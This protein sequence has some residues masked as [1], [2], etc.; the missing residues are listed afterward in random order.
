MK[1]VLITGCAG[2]IGSTIAKKI[3]QK[4]FK[5]YGID[6]LSTGKI[7]NL[8]KKLIFIKGKCEQKKVLEKIKNK[9]IKFFLYQK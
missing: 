5:V 9:N 6:D 4:G 2:F 8:P 3:I 7:K 1:N